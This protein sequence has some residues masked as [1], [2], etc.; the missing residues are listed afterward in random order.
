[1]NG[2]AV[3]LVKKFNVFFYKYLN[4]LKNLTFSLQRSYIRK[5]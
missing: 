5:L 3:F 4:W 1:M 2:I